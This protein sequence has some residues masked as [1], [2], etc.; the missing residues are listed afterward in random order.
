MYSS[1][2]LLEVAN[3]GK[4]GDAAQA[5]SRFF[6]SDRVMALSSLSVFVGHH[7]YTP[8]NI[9]IRRFI[10]GDRPFA[11]WLFG[12][13]KYEVQG[14]DWNLKVQASLGIVGPWAF[15]D[16][17]QTNWHW[18][19]RQLIQSTDPPVPQGWHNQLP[20]EPTFQLGVRWSK[21]IAQIVSR[22][23]RHLDLS[24]F[25]G[26]DLG[27]VWVRGMIGLT[28]RFG[29]IINMI[30]SSEDLPW[31]LR[32]GS[33]H[34]LTGK[35]I[36]GNPTVGPHGMGG[37]GLQDW[38]FYVF[39]RPVVRFVARNMFLDGTLFQD[40]HS[41]PKVPIVVEGEFGISLKIRYFRLSVSAV[42]QSV[43]GDYERVDPSGHRFLR[44]MGGFE[45]F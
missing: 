6:F 21:E 29:Y 3:L 7:M 12:G 31:L 4:L 23:T 39:I 35:P 22:N 33:H 38:E 5:M 42:F 8:N 37:R 27:N 34:P 25:T 26:G 11:A 41:V 40:S 16:E 19:A 17:F 30:P 32:E 1:G 44:I 10:E 2:L 20:N 43:E 14:A 9:T 15:G 24:L 45:G 36:I 13:V 18:L 28:L